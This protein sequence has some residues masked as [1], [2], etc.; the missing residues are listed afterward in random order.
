MRKNGLKQ[1][2]RISGAENSEENKAQSDEDEHG[3]HGGDRN[4]RDP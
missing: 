2:M 4:G 3:S 1:V